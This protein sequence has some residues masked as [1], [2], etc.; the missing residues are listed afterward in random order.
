MAA[1]LRSGGFIHARAGF[2]TLGG[3]A[4]LGRGMSPEGQAL[5]RTAAAQSGVALLTA[6]GLQPMIV[7][8]MDLLKAH[9]SRLLINIG[10]SQANLGDAPEVLRLSPGLVP[11]G[12]ADKAGN[13]VVG[14]AMRDGI[15]VIHML[16]IRG[17]ADR[18]GI[19]YDA[20]PR[21]SAPRGG[22][23][24]WPAAGL[25]LFFVVLFTH[26]RW[27]LEPGGK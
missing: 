3:G 16:N 22:S 7:R 21:K 27:R 6:G 4:E 1:E 23:P 12:E 11:A 26:R 2:Y 15:R 19:P 25:V 17:I 18:Y 5:L 10:G 9:G 20:P 8:K 13:G 14:L 24:L